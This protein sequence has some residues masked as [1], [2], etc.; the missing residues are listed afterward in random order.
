[1]AQDSGLIAASRFPQK[2]TSYE[3]TLNPSSKANLGL[4]GHQA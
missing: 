2:A 3:S 4:P 1:M